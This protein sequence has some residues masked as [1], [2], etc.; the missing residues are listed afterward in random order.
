[1]VNPAVIRDDI[2]EQQMAALELRFRALQ[3]SLTKA[4]AQYTAI[5][6][7]LHSNDLEVRRASVRLQHLQSQLS[8]LGMAMEMLED[9]LN[10]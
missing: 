10:V 5:A 3:D 2:A 4:R 9:R 6:T 8:D 1:M 7:E